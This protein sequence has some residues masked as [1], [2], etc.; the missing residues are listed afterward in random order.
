M[1][2]TPIIPDSRCDHRDLARLL[3][4][5]SFHDEAPGMVFWHPRGLILYD[6]LASLVREE[7][8]RAGYSEIRTPQILRKAVWEASGHWA[9]FREGMF[10]VSD[11]A[12]E[13]A[14]KPVSCPGA[15]IVAGRGVLSYRDLPLR[16][17]ELGTVH[18]DEQSGSL[19]GLL[20]VRQFTQDDGHVLCTMDQAQEEVL[21]FCRSVEPFYR[22][23][24][25]QKISVALSTR[26]A[27]RAGDD[28][29]W[30][31]AES[32]LEGALHALGLPWVHQPG[33]G[34]F[35]GPK[36]EFA[37][38]DAH[39]RSWQCGTIQL[40][41][42]MPAS[43]GVSFVDRDGERR[44]P[45][46]LHRALY[47]SLERFLGILLE[48]HGVALPC[49]LAPVQVAVLPLSEGQLPEAEALCRELSGRGL[50]AEVRSDESIGKRAALAREGAVSFVLVLGPREIEQNTL[51]VK[52]RASMRE[53]PREKAIEYLVA[54]AEIPPLSR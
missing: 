23:F 15:L 41:L 17:C 51:S 9:H 10:R 2:A 44:A 47:G 6:L 45:V 24:G 21:A 22:R 20:R 12:V 43:F 18:R 26:P 39:G 52:D 54:A 11:Q 38:E 36:L 5:F 25:F 27:D 53:L 37:L 13:A 48:H 14:V 31:R 3:D 4:L 49:W 42:G 8:R 30:D 35:Y 32:V 28:A 34:A 46:M 19:H 1:S 33:A 16:L 7:C 50:R 40:D 29:S